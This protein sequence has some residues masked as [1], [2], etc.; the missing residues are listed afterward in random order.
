MPKKPTAPCHQLVSGG[1]TAEER[2][3]SLGL[4][5]PNDEL[6]RMYVEIL[7]AQEAIR[8]QYE[9]QKCPENIL[10]EPR[11]FR[12]LVKEIDYL[13][14]SNY[15]NYG[16]LDQLSKRIKKICPLVVMWID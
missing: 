13:V 1:D 16:V 3:R 12:E 6:F 15:E 7:H 5:H 2:I 4:K 14:Q 10:Q 11:D 9:Q 8:E